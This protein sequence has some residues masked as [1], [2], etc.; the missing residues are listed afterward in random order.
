M[1]ALALGSACATEGDVELSP[2]D[3]FYYP[4]G[5]LQ[6][7]VPGTT[8]GVLYV[9]SSNFDRRFDDGALFAVNLD[10]VRSADGQPLPTLG[11]PPSSPLQLTQ[12]GVNVD[13]SYVSLQSFTGQLAAFAADPANPQRA[14]LFVPARAEGNLLHVIDADG[15]NLTCVGS[16]GRR[17][18]DGA[19]T[20]D[21]TKDEKEESQ[22]RGPGPYA[23]TVAPEGSVYVTHLEPADRPLGS[24]LNLQ[25]YLV[26][27]DA[28]NPVVVRESFLPIGAWGSSDAIVAGRYVVLSGYTRSADRAPMVRLLDREQP[29]RVL[30]ANLESAIQ[31][32]ESRGL[33]F[34][35]A[36]SR[37]FVVGRA[38]DTLIVADVIGIDSA[39]PT[40]RVVRVLPLPA[41]PQALRLI[42]REGR[43][44]LV[45]VAAAGADTV[46]IYDDDAGQ[47]VTQIPGVGRQPFDMSVDL[48]ETGARIFVSNF[49]DGRVG[50]VDISDLSA[51][52]G[53]RLV[54][55]V[56]A[57]QTCL[58]DESGS[59][60][61]SQ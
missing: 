31:V 52:E 2:Q 19:P 5:L 49:G 56:G 15:T 10:A 38:P 57:A 36:R 7:D 40:M 11:N 32:Q 33:A 47:L 50:V 23:V 18:M 41:E 46:V 54:A 37:M 9:A 24:G 30:N 17:C 55:H 44:S 3:R 42:P 60:E 25:S 35:S 39:S 48:Q 43:G 20:L 12:L 21:F 4:T 34:D 53:A 27:V 59:C 1:L 26:R 6:R 28:Q 29:G 16:D 51:P 8:N 45:A 58:I 13:T 14:R 22:P 61:V